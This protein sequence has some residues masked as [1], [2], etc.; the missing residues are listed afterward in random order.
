MC[1]DLPNRK[2][3]EN[4]LHTNWKCMP[5]VFNSKCAMCIQE[6]KNVCLTLGPDVNKWNLVSSL[7]RR[8][9][10]S[11]V[12]TWL[13]V[14]MIWQQRQCAN[15]CSSGWHT[16]QCTSCCSWNTRIWLCSMQNVDTNSDMLD[17]HCASQLMRQLLSSCL[18]RCNG[19]FRLVCHD[20]TT[21]F[22]FF[23]LTISACT[24]RCAS[25]TWV[26]YQTNSCM[27]MNQ[28]YAIMRKNTNL[29]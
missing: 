16:L 15:M 10:G 4:Y 8:R 14:F 27:P 18:S 24:V 11:M 7:H 17:L 28:V 22:F 6:S 5:A 23:F 3:T 21:E 2:P 19:R 1:C 29:R 20:T 26:R 9:A 25:P 12:K 13:C